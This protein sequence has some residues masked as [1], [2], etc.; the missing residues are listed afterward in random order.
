MFYVVCVA[1]QHLCFSKFELKVSHFLR[2]HLGQMADAEHEKYRKAVTKDTSICP[3]VVA[4]S[5]P[6]N[7][8]RDKSLLTRRGK[9]IGTR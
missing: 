9:Y 2:T 7:I 1:E 4:R 3:D 8:V 6:S 5:V